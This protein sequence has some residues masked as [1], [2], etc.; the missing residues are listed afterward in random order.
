MCIKMKLAAEIR[1]PVLQFSEMLKKEQNA[2]HLLLLG[3]YRLLSSCAAKQNILT[4]INM[5]YRMGEVLSCISLPHIGKKLILL[6]KAYR[7]I[8]CQTCLYN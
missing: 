7:S 1:P 6:P 4:H 8:S 3:G 5:Y 2:F